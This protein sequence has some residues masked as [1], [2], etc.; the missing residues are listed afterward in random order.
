MFKKLTRA[1][2]TII[3]ILTLSVAAF[4]CTSDNGDVAEKKDPIE[5][6]TFEGTHDFT[7]PDIDGKYLVKDGKT[8][9]TIVFP[10]TLDS[11]LTTAYEEFRTLFGRATGIT[12]I[13]LAV[14]TAVEYTEDAK[15]ISIGHN[16]Y[17][18]NAGVEYDRLALGNDGVRIITKG[19]SIFLLGGYGAGIVYSVHDFMTIYFNF[20]IYYRNCIQLDTNVKNVP[21][22]QFD[23]TD[24]PDI[25]GYRSVSTGEISG[26][27]DTPT[28]V[29]TMALG[30]TA[31]VDVSNRRYRFRAVES[32][33][34]YMLPIYQDFYSSYSEAS[35]S[36]K[37]S[38]RI[39]NVLEYCPPDHPDCEAEWFSDGGNQL[40]YTA[41]GN[42]ESLKRMKDYCA[43]KIINSLELFPVASS[44]YMNYCTLTIEDYTTH[45]NCTTCSAQTAADDNSRNGAIIRFCNDVYAQVAE[46]MAQPENEPYA[47]P[48]LQLVFFAYSA[49]PNPPAHFD[50]DLGE[51]VAADNCEMADGVGV[52]LA[53]RGSSSANIYHEKNDKHRE[54]VDSWSS[55]TDILWIWQYTGHHY[56]VTYFDDALSFMNS[57]A[58]QYYASV[59][60]EY[61]FDEKI[62]S[63][64]NNTHFAKLEAY[65][66]HKLLWDSSL[67]SNVLIQ[68]FFDNMFVDA[69]DSMQALYFDIKYHYQSITDWTRKQNLFTPQQYPYPVLVRWVGMIDKALA[70][71]EHYKVSN[72]DLYYVI[73]DRI[74]CEAV[75]PLYAIF[76]IHAPLLNSPVTEADLKYYKS[77]LQPIA[78]TYN[79][80]TQTNDYAWINSIYEKY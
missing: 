52:Y 37:P 46:W 78:E 62:D 34:S 67:D 53:H 47:R 25:G 58:I 63:G 55:L 66:E 35:T 29:D 28:A 59:G 5:K 36:G 44:P 80:E 54:F 38:A 68:N 76:E 69:S 60:V 21:L 14:D 72:P 70:D 33:N 1:F 43:R 11:V 71:I 51:W 4:A 45:C 27:Y 42:E 65:V 49:I 26:S 74:D 18:E 3:L 32:G 56:N 57:D 15:Y 20:D 24:I 50:D 19:D 9:Y 23:V 16:A 12:S 2:V 13:G 8:D 73:K 6:V 64:S 40:C 31:A 22:K 48:T 30:S 39:H 77:R 7:A 41:R 61:F 17:V 75:F 10:E 79:F